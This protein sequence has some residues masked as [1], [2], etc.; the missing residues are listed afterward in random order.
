MK[1]LKI[2][3]MQH[4]NGDKTKLNNL[5]NNFAFSNEDAFLYLNMINYRLIKT[6]RNS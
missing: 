1:F 4:L 6:F 5:L 2:L 3:E